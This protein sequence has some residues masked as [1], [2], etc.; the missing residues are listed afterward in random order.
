MLKQ[1]IFLF[2]SIIIRFNSFGKF[3]FNEES[4]SINIFS[5]IKI[6]ELLIAPQKGNYTLIADGNKL[7]ELDET[8]IIKASLI[9]DKI[10]I[11]AFENNLGTFKNI[12]FVSESDEKYFKIKLL[13][14]DRKPRFYDDNLSI[15]IDEKLGLKLINTTEI[16]NY[17]AG[18]SEAEAGKSAGI[19]FYKVQSVLA[20]TYALAHLYKHLPEGFNLCDQVH[21]Q[22]FNGKSINKYIVDAVIETK[23]QVVVDKDLQLI[24]AAFHSN[25][26][27]Q[28]ANSE[29]VWGAT[30]TYLK[31]VID[32]F[33]LK[34][35]NAY[36]KK[37][38]AKEE[39][40]NYLK[41]KHKFP[42]Q[43]DSA[44]SSALSFKNNSRKAYLEFEN[45]KIPFKT[46]R[47]D[48]K[49]KSAFFD[50]DF[51]KE[52]NNV[53]FSGRGFGHGIGL[54]QEGAIYMTKSG[55]S[56]KDVLNFY[57]QNIHIIDLKELHFFK[58]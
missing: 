48:L 37:N 16:D 27:G 4:V 39:W 57:Y 29:D 25:S 34:M 33:S 47:T 22:A 15:S 2:F 3:D 11:K 49:L 1:F 46:L 26:G 7:L 36:W 14:P 12:S 28:T 42:V 13:N 19:E 5:S 40:L 51:D 30:T 50:I 8:S 44:V 53:I 18:V 24:T 43:S 20:R 10:E 35:P 31:S 52:N 23:G 58:E 54:S 21:C 41:S 38:M 55:Y 32:T 6:N 56:Y 9:D 17:I 45:I